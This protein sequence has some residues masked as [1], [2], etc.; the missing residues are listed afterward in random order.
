MPHLLGMLQSVSLARGRPVSTQVSAED[1]RN[2]QASLAQSLL[3]HCSFLWV[4]GH[5]RFCLCPPRVSVSPVLWKFCNQVP[6]VFKVKFPWG[7]R[8]LWRISRL[9]NLLWDL[10][11]LQQCENF[12]VI[13]V[14]QFVGCLLCSSIVELMATSSKRTY[15]THHIS[16]VCCSES[17]CHC[18]RSL[19]TCASTGDTQTLKQGLAQSLV[20]SLLLSLGPSVHKV[21]FAPS[22]YLQQL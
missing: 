13:I 6:L 16:Q 19:L 9:V 3:S 20:G 14:L 7:S 5:T 12:F 18:G 1:S 10:E 22:K 17:L 4:L 8:S 15:A 11:L 2:S 21:L